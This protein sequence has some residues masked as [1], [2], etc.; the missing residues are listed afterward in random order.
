MTP[1]AYYY[2]IY[3]GVIDYAGEVIHDRFDQLGYSMYRNLEE[4]VVKACKGETHNTEL[5]HVCDFYKGDLSRAQLEAQLPLLQ[6]Y[7]T[8]KASMNQ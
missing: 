4:L 7:V 3:Y 8:L 2:Q 6:H 5:D 1:E